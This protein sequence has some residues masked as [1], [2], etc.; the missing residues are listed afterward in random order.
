MIVQWLDVLIVSFATTAVTY[1]ILLEYYKRK[2]EKLQAKIH[3]QNMEITE[4][5]KELEWLHKI[6]GKDTGYDNNEMS[7]VR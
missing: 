7:Q 2:I 5:T 3:W 1:L 6:T 4:K